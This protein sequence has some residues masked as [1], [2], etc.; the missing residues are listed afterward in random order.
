MHLQ[1]ESRGRRIARWLGSTAV[2]SLPVLLPIA[3]AIVALLVAAPESSGSDDIVWG[4]IAIPLGAAFGVWARAAQ[5]VR[6]G[7]SKARAWLNAVGSAT[8][9]V[10]IGGVLWFEALEATCHGAYECPF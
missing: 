3:P 6:I 2:W 5:S 1:R 10:L 7:D 9:G 4:L 8:I